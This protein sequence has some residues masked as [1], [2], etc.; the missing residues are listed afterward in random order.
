MALSLGRVV[1]GQHARLIT[2]RQQ[3]DSV[4]CNHR[5]GLVFVGGAFEAHLT[6]TG[7]GFG[8]GELFDLAVGLGFYPVMGGNPSDVWVV[9]GMLHMEG[10][11]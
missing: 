2:L 5:L 10:V 7:F 6:V 1:Q 3:F 8:C 4:P 11:A 9:V